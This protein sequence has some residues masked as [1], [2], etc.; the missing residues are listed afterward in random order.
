[1]RRPMLVL[2]L[3]LIVMGGAAGLFAGGHVAKA[4]DGMQ[5]AIA[6]PFTKAGFAVGNIALSGQER[7]TPQAAYAALGIDKGGSIFAVRPTRRA[8]GCSCCPGSRMPRCAAA[9]PI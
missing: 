3:V 9:S 1:L 2:T 5:T 4:I 7:T 6:A 8:R